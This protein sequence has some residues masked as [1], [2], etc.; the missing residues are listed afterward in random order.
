[1]LPPI[2]LALELG[3]GKVQAPVPVLSVVTYPPGATKVQPRIV[4]DGVRGAIF[5]YAA[6]GPLGALVSS[7]ASTAGVDPYG[8]VYPAGFSAGASSAFSGTNFTINSSGAFFYTGPPALGNLYLSISNSSGTDPK[9][10]PYV[11]G[12]VSYFSPSGAGW[13]R[14]DGGDVQFNNNSFVGTGLIS[15]DSV[16]DLVISVGPTGGSIGLDAVVQPIPLQAQ[17]GIPTN[18]FTTGILYGNANGTASAETA[19][20]TAGVLAST[21]TAGG[22]TAVVNPTTPTR[23]TN[24]YT[25]D[26]PLIP[27]TVYVLRVPF[28]GVWGLQVMTIF[29]NIS[30][31]TTALA[32]LGAA[33]ATGAASGDGI[34]GWIEIEVFIVTAATCRISSKGYVHDNTVNV[35]NSATAG[36][37]LSGTVAT[38]VAIAGGN[39]LSIS[40]S[41]AASVAAQTI[42]PEFEIFT[43]N[44]G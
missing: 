18:L 21:R 16:G 14:L 42:T 3:G 30:G 13:V 12:V 6:G 38:G 32:T 20:G 43:R 4:I 34:N 26:N 8:N 39:T 36:S 23:I 9:G 33:F 24:Q 35:N 44:G 17:A 25:L 10:N 1:M 11:S 31:T 41:F 22:I 40:A 27:N 2:P 5:E 28:N 15:F 19:G 29:A 7:W 37:G